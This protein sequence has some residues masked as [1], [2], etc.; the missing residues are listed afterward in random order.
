M[1]EVLAL[2]A[3]AF[4]A[5]PVAGLVVAL[6]LH[7]RLNRLDVEGLRAQVGDLERQLAAVRRDLAK[8]GEPAAPTETAA[9]P[10]PSPAPAPVPAP[11]RPVPPPTVVPT[12]APEK[13][14]VPV[15]LE[16]RIGARWATWIGVL[17]IV[18]SVGLLLRWSFE[19]GLIG[20]G[21]RVITGV[22]S[23]LVL[24][25]SGLVLRRRD[26]LPYLAPGLSGGGLAILYLSVWAAHQVYGFLGSTAAFGALVAVTLAGIAVSLAASSQATAVL[27]VLCGLATPV[28]VSTDRPDERTLLVYLFVLG[29]LV[30]GVAR[31]RSWPALTRLA[32]L[33]SI[34]LYIPILVRQP[35]AEAPWTRLALGTLLF[36]LYLA[37]PIAR[38][39][40]ERS[41]ADGLDLAL[42][43]GNAMA[44]CA[45]AYVTLEWWR[46]SLQGPWAIAA[47][48]L[49]VA[50]GEAYRR[51]VPGDLPTALVHH[52]AAVV[53]AGLAIPLVLDGAWVT[54]GWMLEG[55]VLLA[56]APRVATGTTAFWGGLL[57][58]A[59]AVARL[60]FLDPYVDPGRAAVWNPV[61]ASD[62]AVA[63]LLVL[64]GRIV[65]RMEPDGFGLPLSGAALRGVLRFAATGSLALLLWREPTGSWPALLL[66]LLFLAVGALARAT[67]DP[68]LVV[69]LPLLALLTAA[70]VFLEDSGLAW[71]AAER[72]VNVP[73]LLRV[74][75]CVAMLG[76]GWMLRRGDAT[77]MEA[78]ARVALA[79]LGGVGLLGALSAAWIEPLRWAAGHA[80]EA[81]DTETASALTRR[82]Q[83]GLSIL[84]TLYAAATLTIGFVRREELLRWAALALFGFVVAKVF[85]VDLSD[86]PGIYRVVSFLVLG[87]V[88]LGVSYFYQRSSR[89]K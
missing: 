23:G 2:L 66:V 39:W 59:A 37:V 43:V 10:R 41:P 32:W 53:L 38:A 84:W 25:A 83:T 67:R 81:G 12:R 5:L 6:L 17:A 65:S 3:L 1:E 78:R 20:P 87:L 36:A 68:A 9:P 58:V 30:L 57:A 31:R 62:L 51:R 79:A 29:A 18:T 21:A 4:L 26:D 49:Y 54:V 89:K 63:A 73:S 14:T 52:G 13:G 69:A 48:L 47:A 64:A 50:V 85:L 60:A 44:Y 74:G 35:G 27:A 72:F 70:R 16:Q 77:E 15:S 24:L 88:L 40:V 22:V 56:L 34:L 55:L 33:G 42:V 19:R 46:P 82:I 75:A 7:R 11:V 45:F 61:F 8:T 86:L 28:L 80:R 71:S 76:V